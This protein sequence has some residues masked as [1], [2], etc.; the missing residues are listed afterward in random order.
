MKAFIHEH[1]YSQSITLNDKRFC[2][3]KLSLNVLIPEIYIISI[4]FI[5]FKLRK[6]LQSISVQYVYEPENHAFS[7]VRHAIVFLYNTLA[8]RYKGQIKTKTLTLVLAILQTPSTFPS[9]SSFL[10]M[11]M[12]G[13]LHKLSV[14]NIKDKA[15]NCP[16]TFRQ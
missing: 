13:S 7:C 8:F 10:Q 3:S 4:S 9:H 5:T 15:L 11:I 2:P 6:S 12:L 14:D 16:T 1:L